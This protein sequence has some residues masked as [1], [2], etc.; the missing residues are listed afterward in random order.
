M[1]EP[2]PPL[3]RG[4]YTPYRLYSSGRKLSKRAS[5]EAASRSARPGRGPTLL[6]HAPFPPVSEPRWVGDQ[7][8][9]D[10]LLLLLVPYNYNIYIFIYCMYHVRVPLVYHNTISILQKY[11][12]TLRTINQRCRHF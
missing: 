5:S 7:I 3:V 6:L 1:I 4:A 8:T 2:P 11:I 12:Y 10:S 9:S